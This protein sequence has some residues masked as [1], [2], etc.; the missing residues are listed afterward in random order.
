[1]R[2]ISVVILD[3]WI[4]GDRRCGSADGSVK[5]VR[6]GIVALSRAYLCRST[7]VASALFFKFVA[8]RPPGPLQTADGTIR[9]AEIV[10]ESL[11]MAAPAIAHA[12][13]LRLPLLTT[14]GWSDVPSARVLRSPAQELGCRRAPSVA[15]VRRA[16]TLDETNET[17]AASTQDPLEGTAYRTIAMLGRGA[18]GEV[19]E[20][21]HLP[22][23]RRVVV[24][25]LHEQFAD[26]A[27]VA[28]RLRVEARTLALVEHPNV[29]A[30][31][32]FGRTRAGRP[33]LVTERLRGRT[34]TEELRARGF[35]PVAE[36]VDIVVQVL[37]GLEAAHQQGIVHRDVKPANIFLCDAT[38]TSPRLAKVLDFGVAKIIGSQSL[39]RTAPEYATK[40]GAFLGTPRFTA[41][42]QM[43]TGQIDA[44]TDVYAAAL[45]LYTLV[46]GRGPFAHLEEARAI[47]KAHL[48]EPPVPPSKHAR[49]AIP[50]ELDAAV[51]R[52]LA[53]K[54][55]DRFPSAATFAS[56]LRRIAVAVL[57]RDDDT[58]ETFLVPQAIEEGS[59]PTSSPRGED[60]T[61]KTIP[62]P[63]P[64]PEGPRASR[65]HVAAPPILALAGSRRV[66]LSLRTLVLVTLL[67]ALAVL[68]LI[69]LAV[70]HVG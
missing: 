26:N 48:T 31:A 37:A 36:A 63:Q 58:E 25:L 29:V 34:L 23:G 47:M 52:A 41:P 59:A 30:V 64:V 33:F 18:M 32:D 27:P 68:G 46:A 62:V 44:R 66:G 1:M 61:E 38:P 8:Q 6:K 65:E 3:G 24:K 67:T 60:E 15:S 19:V 39:Q 55:A 7:R 42:E 69:T 16:S 17:P 5:N 2:P 13:G 12:T 54:P 20:A 28:D 22:L 11:D 50:A 4:R 51:L 21:E 56:E 9:R 14:C 35:L 45:V 53:K 43:G 49:Q 57:G 10:A 70:K 40:K